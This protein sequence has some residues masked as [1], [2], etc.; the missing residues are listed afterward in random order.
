MEEINRMEKTAEMAG[1]RPEKQLYR[2]KEAATYLGVSPS[3][4]YA[5]IADG[6]IKSV[7]LAGRMVRIRREDL[8]GFVDAGRAAA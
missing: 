3:W 2:P 4:V 7:H 6:T 8:V 5:R 1:N